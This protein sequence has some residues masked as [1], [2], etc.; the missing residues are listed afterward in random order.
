MEGL[1]FA[2]HSHFSLLTAITY[3]LIFLH[4]FHFIIII[5]ANVQKVHICPLLMESCEIFYFPSQLKSI[6][7]E[8]QFRFDIF[9]FFFCFSSCT[10]LLH[11]E[12]R[13]HLYALRVTTYKHKEILINKLGTMLQ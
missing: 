4:L 6:H 7:S 11:I 10:K 2:V 3:M 9:I 12:K 5:M 1:N 8:N 13:N